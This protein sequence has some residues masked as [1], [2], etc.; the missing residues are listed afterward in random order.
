ML[1]CVGLAFIGFSVQIIVTTVIVYLTDSYA[2]YA[3][4]AVAAVAFGENMTAAWLPLATTYMYNDLGFQWASSLLG[5][6]G[7]ALTLAPV[8]LLVNGESIRKKSKFIKEATYH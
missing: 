8:V 2:K 7:L 6:V 5:F 4:S 3:G 1:P